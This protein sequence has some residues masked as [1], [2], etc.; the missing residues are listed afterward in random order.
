MNIND[1]ANRLVVNPPDSI[2]PSDICVIKL[3]AHCHESDCTKELEMVKGIVHCILSIPINDWK[4]L[5]VLH[6]IFPQ[7]FI[8]SFGSDTT[9]LDDAQ[10][11]ETWRRASPI[12]KRKLE[13]ERGW[14]FADWCYWMEPEQRSWRWW[15][16]KA[17]SS[18]VVLIEIV[19]IDW[20]IP[21]AAFRVM[22][23]KCGFSK[24]L[25]EG[26]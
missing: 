1:E 16:V 10:W 20:P 11:L 22:L 9:E 19:V 8:K 18:S 21:L 5:N 13:E 3:F 25:E 6:N 7:W 2:H 15:R 23:Q 24:V 26:S 12:E 14:S 17:I 4:N